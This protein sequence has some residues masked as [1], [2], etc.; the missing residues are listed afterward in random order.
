MLDVHIEGYDLQCHVLFIKNK[1]SN[2]SDP[3]RNITSASRRVNEEGV[4]G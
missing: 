1:F 2:Y 3:M 4:K